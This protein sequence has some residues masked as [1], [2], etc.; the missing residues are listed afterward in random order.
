VY[1]F[2]IRVPQDDENTTHWWFT[3]FA[4]HD[5]ADVDPELIDKAHYF[6]VPVE[7]EPYTTAEHQDILAWTTQGPIVDRTREGLG[8]TDRGITMFRNMLRRELKKVANGE[9]PILVV[10]TPDD[11]IPVALPLESDKAHYSDGFRALLPRR[12]W[13]YSGLGEQLI[14]T[15]ERASRR[16]LA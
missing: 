5:A 7:G 11:D 10:R 1:E 16:V 3:A 4:P 9:D 15:F 6:T 14:E 12:H 8:S 2:Q 13:K